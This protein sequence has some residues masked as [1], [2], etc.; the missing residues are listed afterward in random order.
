MDYRG[1]P[2]YWITG[3]DGMVGALRGQELEDLR[4]SG[5]L[6]PLGIE[7]RLEERGKENNL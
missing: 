5:K 6:N 3:R 4:N 2:I 7:G 1:N